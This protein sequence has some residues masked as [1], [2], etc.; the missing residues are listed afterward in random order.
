[1]VF[2]ITEHQVPRAF[3]DEIDFVGIGVNIRIRLLAG[4]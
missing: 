1:V 2:L 4:M 3:N